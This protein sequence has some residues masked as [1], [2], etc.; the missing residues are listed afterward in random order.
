MTWTMPSAFLVSL[1]LLYCGALVLVGVGL[2]RLRPGKNQT[3]F[4]V[5]VVIAARNEAR[6]I[7]ACL[8]AV[9]AQDYPAEKVEVLVVD[10]RSQDETAGIVRSL[11]ERDA[12]VRL[13]EVGDIP[14]GVSP[15]KHA[16]ELGVAHS[17]GELIL[18]TDA[19]CVPGPSWI[20]ELVA[21]FEQDVGVVIGVV[22]Q[23]L[24]P[25]PGLV[26]GLQALELLSYGVFTAGAVGVGWAINSNA[27]SFAYRRRVF[28]QVGGLGASSGVVSGDDVLFVQRVAAR[29]P[30]RVRF[31]AAQ[32]AFVRTAPAGTLKDFWQQRFRW[33]SKCRHYRA[34]DLAFLSTAF[35]FFLLV[36]VMLAACAMGWVDWRVPVSCWGAK[37]LFELAVMAKGC[38]AFG[39]LRLLGYFPLAE[40]LHIPYILVAA[41]MGTLFG[42]AWKGRRYQAVVSSRVMGRSSYETTAVPPDL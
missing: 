26:R 22:E 20:R 3:L 12:R 38:S 11:S 29:T 24:P 5:S 17:R 35:L 33:A 10:D 32:G 19:D 2:F 21:L 42:F 36:C 40:L 37:V 28:D 30:W 23:D 7:S 41:A 27:G 15:K 13:V 9:L 1:A 6:H 18:T 31:A 25:R 14:P 39:R 16:V 4:D 34:A 8:E